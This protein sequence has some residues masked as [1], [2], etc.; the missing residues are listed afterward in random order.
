MFTK[1][2]FEAASAAE[3][4]RLPVPATS[5]RHRPGVLVHVPARDVH[6]TRVGQPQ[7]STGTRGSRCLCTPGTLSAMCM[8]AGWK[9]A[10]AGFVVLCPSRWRFG[11]GA[12]LFYVASTISFG[13]PVRQR[14]RVGLRI[15]GFEVVKLP[16]FE[17]CDALGHRQH[18]LPPHSPPQTPEFHSTGCR[19]PKEPLRELRDLLSCDLT[20]KEVRRCLAL[21]VWDDERGRMVS[22]A[23]V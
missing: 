23:E 4:K 20:W 1:T 16:G 7:E 3:R 18:R 14:R 10:T 21:K 11:F 12:Y 6:P 19:K 2:R 5:R 17:P 15:V 13:C 9:V 22:L 8:M